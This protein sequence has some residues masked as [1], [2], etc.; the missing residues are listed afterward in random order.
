MATADITS[1]PAVERVIRAGGPIRF[2][3]GQPSPTAQLRDIVGAALSIDGA[4]TATGAQLYADMTKADTGTS[5]DAAAGLYLG[6]RDDV[7]AHLSLRGSC[8]RAT[9]DVAVSGATAER[10]HLALGDRVM[11]T[12]F[13]LPRPVP[14]T[15]TGIYEVTDLHAPTT[16]PAPTCS[17]G[18][19]ARPCPTCRRS[20]PRPP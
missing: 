12:G 10:L 15:L 18:R 8:P 17:P 13:R 3:P 4:Q 6:Y 9:G 20:P 14:L 2:G 16:G 7:C 1:A 5:T 11:F 19:A